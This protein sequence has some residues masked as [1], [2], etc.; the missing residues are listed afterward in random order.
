VVTAIEPA[1]A[2]AEQKRALR[3]PPA[4]LTAWEAYQR[5]LWHMAKLV[6]ANND[7]AREFLQQAIT[8][9]GTFVAAHAWRSPVRPALR[10]SWP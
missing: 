6:G 5:G 8:L 9:D 2:D 1:P 10:W 4:S 3:K 7:R